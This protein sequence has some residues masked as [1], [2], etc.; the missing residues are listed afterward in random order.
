VRVGPYKKLRDLQQAR[1]TLQ[2]NNIDFMLLAL[3]PEAG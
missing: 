1:A 2:R 3:K